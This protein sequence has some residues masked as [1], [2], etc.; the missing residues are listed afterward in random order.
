MLY[1]LFIVEKNIYNICILK[2]ERVVFFIIFCSIM[3]VLEVFLKFYKYILKMMI[4]LDYVLL[5]VNVK[6]NIFFL[7]NFYLMY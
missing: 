3:R 5:K 4:Y 2:L 7:N 1:L 6:V